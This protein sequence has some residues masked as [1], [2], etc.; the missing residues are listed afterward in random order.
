MKSKFAN[1][2]ARREDINTLSAFAKQFDSTEDFLSQ[3]ALLG[4]VETADAFRGEGESE[5]VTLSTIH[6]AKG[7]EW[8]VIFLIWLTEGMFPS[9]RSVENPDALEEERRLFYVGITRCRDELYLT[10]PDM[11]LNASYSEAL[12]RPSRFL[13]EIPENLLESD[14]HSDL[15]TRRAILE[16]RRP[17]NGAPGQRD[18]R[19]PRWIVDSRKK[20]LQQLLRYLPDNSSVYYRYRSAERGVVPIESGH[21]SGMR[22]QP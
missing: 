10:Y 12:Q 3:L 16:E 2:E 4:A 1:Y 22:M 9:A 21:L 17:A 6:Q 5:K 18:S 11:R 14:S 20:D 19:S 8:K 15:E 13:S 7:L